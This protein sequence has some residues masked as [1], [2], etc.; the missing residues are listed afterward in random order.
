M[1]KPLYIIGNGFDMHHHLKTSFYD[2]AAYLKK[3]DSNLHYLLES[4]LSY[5]RTDRELWK[6]FEENLANLDIDSILSDNNE[7]LP[8]IAS[9]EFRSRDLHSFPDVMDEIFKNLT[10]DLIAV[11]KKFILQVEISKSSL[12]YKVEID[13]NA[14]FFSFNYTD[15]LERLYQI[16]SNQ[17]LYIHNSAYNKDDNIVLG[18]G[19]NPESFEEKKPEP[20]KG[21]TEDELERWREE[22]DDWDYS[23]DTGKENIMKYFLQS[24]KPTA[25]IISHHY[26]FFQN[27]FNVE[28]VFVFG[29]S[30]SG[31]DM[32]YF[33]Q[34]V[35]S[36]SA[37]TKWTVSY[38]DES[39]QES[40]LKA[41][42]SLG[43]K[44]ENIK[45]L[46]L[47]DLRLNN[48]NHN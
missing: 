8:N 29:H 40:H 14:Q 10:E 19:I 47:E 21:L 32:P 41:L 43:I 20:P 15:T 5:P 27:L 30:L 13:K 24:Y 42:I 1:S 26:S 38:Y 2:F 23:F 31:I 22:N 33:Q 16:A 45:L 36:T 35:K 4:H 46:E 44:K 7:Y 3:H 18:H 17:I 9:D 39:E 48:A 37:K 6:R 28:E 25:D 12:Q 34:I 11:F